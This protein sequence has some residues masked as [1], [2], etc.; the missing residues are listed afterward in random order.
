VIRLKLAPMAGSAKALE[1]FSPVGI[2]ELQAPDQPRRNNVIYMAPHSGLSQVLSAG[3]DLT[4]IA[5]TQNSELSP[6]PS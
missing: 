4:S 1:V 2:P 6:L 3:F 5:H